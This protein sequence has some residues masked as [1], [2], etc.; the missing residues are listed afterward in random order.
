M[1]LDDL[2]RRMESLQGQMDAFARTSLEDN[3]E[4]VLG[5]QKEQLF[6]GKDRNG[7]DIR[8]YY[9]EDLQSRGGY[10]KT[11]QAARRYA[12]WKASLTYPSHAARE[13]DAPNLYINGRFHSEIGLQ[14]TDETMLVTG[15]TAYALQIIGKYESAFGLSE[16]SMRRLKPLLVGKILEQMKSVIYG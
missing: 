3:R 13:A 7:Q 4:E 16:E 9:S 15:E 14:F 11:P 10:F 6:S 8:P 12:D 1:T 5:L 2:I